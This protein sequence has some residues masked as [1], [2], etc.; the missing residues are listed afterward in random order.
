MLPLLRTISIRPIVVS[1]DLLEVNAIFT[2][3]YI[4]SYDDTGIT[5]THPLIRSP[6]T[7][8]LKG[9]Y[10]FS[11]GMRLAR[12]TS[13]LADCFSVRARQFPMTGLGGSATDYN[14]M[15]IV[16]PRCSSV[17]LSLSSCYFRRKWPFSPYPA[18]SSSLFLYLSPSLSSAPSSI[19]LLIVDLQPTFC[20]RPADQPANT[21]RRRR[22]W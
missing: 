20:R 9:W 7:D 10:L 19:R 5:T 2:L 13:S 14:A 8:A 22:D 12:A 6:H 3:H 4:D 17:R 21:R 15:Q 11:N 18:I 16:R 1:R